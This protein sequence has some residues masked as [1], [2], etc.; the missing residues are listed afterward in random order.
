MYL[1]LKAALRNKKHLTLLIVSFLALVLLTIANVMEISAL[2]VISNADTLS[3]LVDGKKITLTA[4]KSGKDTNPLNWIID[5]V[6]TQTNINSLKILISV[7]V[8]VAIFKAITLF[9]SRYM[10]QVLS[11]RISRDLRQQYFAHIQLLPMSFYQQYNI[12]SLSSRVVG[13]ANQ[14][15]TSI[16]SSI[17]NYLHMPFTVSVAL[18]FCFYLSWQLA[19]VIFVGFPMIIFPI[20]L[21]SKRVRR[22]TRQLQSNQEKFAGVLI[23]FL[24]GIQTVKIFAM[25]AFSFKKYKEQNDRMAI[26]ESKT[27][28]YGHLTRPILH[29]VTTMCLASVVL[30][31]LYTLKLTLPELIVFCGT[32]QISYESIKKF[33][34]ENSN[35]QRGIVAAERMYEVLNLHPEIEDKEGALELKGFNDKIELDHIWFRYGQEWVIKDLCMTVRKG[36]TVAIVGATGSGKSTIVQLLPRLYEVQKGEIRIDGKPLS[37]YTQK[38]LRE[39]IAFVSQKPFLFSDTVGANIAFG[40]DF[41]KAEIEGAARRAHAEE[42][43][44]RLPQKYDTILAEA[45]QNLS[46]GQQQRLA[47]A[48]AL[49]K[50]APILILDEATSSLDALSEHKI[51]EAIG[52]LHGEITQIIIAHRL[53]TIENADR[54]LYI[55]KG[56]KIAEGTKDELLATCEPFRLTWEA[57]YHIEQISPQPV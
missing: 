26:L 8:G 53:G 21:L 23:D 13:D 18:L 42:F 11:I 1:L 36:E 34:D 17:T 14:I 56:E 9:W 24:A 5:T 46:G 20:I 2:G 35:I 29:M 16:N 27:A 33:A 51:K 7:L 37:A 12:G 48:R 28:K 4:V 19:L 54:I 31:G 40:K 57:L 30:F 39:Q 6:C 41:S 22:V 49:V 25:E 43:I 52:S 55:E 38:S 47:I 50:H 10:T 15:A 44:L 32:L 45:G 3:Q